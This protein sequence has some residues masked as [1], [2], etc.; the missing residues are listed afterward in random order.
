ML[1]EFLN[2]LA[3][4]KVYRGPGRIRPVIDEGKATPEFMD[5]LM[6]GRLRTEYTDARPLAGEER[7]TPP[8]Y[9]IP[10]SRLGA[11]LGSEYDDQHFVLLFSRI[12][13]QKSNVSLPHIPLSC[14]CRL[15]LYL[16][17]EDVQAIQLCET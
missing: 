2:D 12:N 17:V 8:L 9:T 6:D 11:L 1:A 15:N 10:A 16:G 4:G 3:T 13:T 14:V 5:F 7:G